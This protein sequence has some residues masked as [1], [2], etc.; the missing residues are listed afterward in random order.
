LHKLSSKLINE[1]Q[2]ICLED[3]QVKNMVKNHKLAKSI[4]DCSWSKFVEFLKYKSDWYG[5]NLVQIDKFFPSSKT[6][7]NCGNIKKD[8]T[9]KDR[10]YHCSSCRTTIDRDYNASLN[11]LEEGLRILKKNCRDDRDSSVN[12]QTLVC[13]S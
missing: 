7:S 11:I 10:E 8:L 2:V 12:I 3:L 6:C 4:S 13:S 1:N 5:R 9:L